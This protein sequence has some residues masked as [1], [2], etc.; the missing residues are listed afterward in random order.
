M[1]KYTLM[2]YIN[3]NIQLKQNKYDRNSVFIQKKGLSL[4]EI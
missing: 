1:Y 2:C 4:R 3:V